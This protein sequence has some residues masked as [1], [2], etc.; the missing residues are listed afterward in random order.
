V[1]AALDALRN[2]DPH[3]RA[4]PRGPGE[5]EQRAALRDISEGFEFRDIGHA[6]A[7]PCS[8]WRCS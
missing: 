7:S 1:T 6:S 5:R 8:W 2:V 4:D 3:L